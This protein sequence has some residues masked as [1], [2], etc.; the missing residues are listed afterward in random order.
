MALRKRICRT[1]DFE[2]QAT[3]TDDG[4][5]F[6]LGPSMAFPVGDVF[7]YLSP[8]TVEEVL[9]QAVFQA[10]L[11]GT[12]WRWNASRFLALLRH[13][14]G[15]KVPAP[16]QRMRSDDLL[17]A[18]FP[19]PGAMPGTTPRPATSSRRTTRWCSKPPATASPRP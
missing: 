12:R 7:N 18:V 8:N 5:N 4:L 19:G 15:K 11:F 14:G 9:T 6:S 2:L 13:S 17:A 16:L 10:P 1:F 3:A